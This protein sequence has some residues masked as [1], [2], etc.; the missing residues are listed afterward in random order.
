MRAIVIEKPG[1]PENMTLGSYRKP[2]PRKEEL[3][4]R[5][6]ATALNRADLLQRTGKYPPPPGASP[7]LGL[8]VAGTVEAM[9]KG[10][11]GWK[12]GDRVFGLLAGGGYA[13][14]AVLH[15]EMAMRI[16]GN[17][18]FEEAAAIPEAFLTAYQA[19]FWLGGLEEHETVLIHAGASGVGTSAL[20]LVVASQARALVTASGSKHEACLSLGASVAINYHEE[21]F[22]SAVHGATDGRGAD[23]I[24]DFIG[25]PYLARN[26]TALAPDGR[27]VLLA[28]MGGSEVERFD[29]RLLFKKRAQVTATTLRHRS[30]EYK[31]NLTQD[32]A[33]FML[34]LFEDAR[35]K[36]II[37]TV[38]HWK[39][40]ADAHRRMEANR[41]VG[42][43][44]L[45]VA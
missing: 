6:A 21:D 5:V 40:V 9:G 39:N 7:L 35:L 36:P 17:L 8:E 3:L 15:Q 30:L 41:N 31:I 2:R 34:P 11:E 18:S 44:V 14:F 16:P 23:L 33:G 25:A 27:I 26:L 28:T 10:V 42:K 32:F 45:K 38:Y 29:L 20:Q 12:K 1:E 4:I 24:L 19:L 22:V 13:Q 37:D 43:I